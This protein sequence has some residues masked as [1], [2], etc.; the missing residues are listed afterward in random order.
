[1]AELFGLFVQHLVAGH[2]DAAH[3]PDHRIRIGY[4]TEGKYGTGL[5]AFGR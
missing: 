2:L 3:F 4:G 1:M 5:D